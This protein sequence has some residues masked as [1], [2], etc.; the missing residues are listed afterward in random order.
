MSVQVQMVEASVWTKRM[1]AALGNG[2]KGG[3]WYSLSDKVYHPRTLKA[4][5]KRVASNR[6][7]AGVDKVSINRFRSNARYYLE[8]L[9]QALRNGTYRPAPVRRVYIPKDRKK[10]RPLGIPTVK[11]RIV[12]T[13]L[14]MVLEP[15]FEREFLLS[16]YGFRP[17]RG[18]KDAL[19]EVDRLLKE[20]YTWV[21]DADIKS[22]FDTIPHDAL[23][24]CIREKVSDGKIL[25]LIELFLIDLT[26]DRCGYK[27]IRYADDFVVLCRSKKEATA[28]LAEIQVWTEQN[29][30]HVSP[31]KTHIGNSL[32]DGHGF[33]FLGYRFEGGRRNVRSK[34]L[35]GIKDKIRAKTRRTRGDSIENI[36]A[37]L[38]PTIKGWFEYFKHS[39]YYTFSSLDGFIRRRLRA[40]LRKQRK[41]PGSGR[42]KQDHRRWPNAFLAERGL[43][44]M[45][46]AYVLACQSR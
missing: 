34:S 35:K 2:V 10:T 39:H 6:G 8:E 36:I 29:G 5:W 9:E 37:D 45:H 16:S 17:E 41:R 44:T 14:K 23:M 33:E 13:A 38:N 40:I 21:V 7:A 4:A 32:E 24:D 22:Y 42:S 3:K 18:C 20:G 27:A 1:L 28:A 43:F 11:D 31:E 19:R 25:H 26:L 46:K 15:I 12:Q 30:L